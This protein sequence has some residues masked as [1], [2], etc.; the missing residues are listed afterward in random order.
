VGLLQSRSPGRN[1]PLALRQGLPRGFGLSSE[2]GSRIEGISTVL[3]HGLQELA[4]LFMSHAGQDVVTA[5]LDEFTAEFMR[6]RLPPVHEW[7]I[8]SGPSPK[9]SSR[10]CSR[11]KVR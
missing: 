2:S 4:A 6:D 10:V 8:A 1:I 3:S 9:L 11:G 7:L 5:C